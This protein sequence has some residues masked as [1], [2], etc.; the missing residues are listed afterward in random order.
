MPYIGKISQAAPTINH[1][2][3]SFDATEEL[4]LLGKDHA[5]I[6]KDDRIIGIVCVDNLLEEYKSGDIST[7]TIEEFIE[8]L[9]FVNE[10]EYRSK[11][12][13][14]MLVNNVEHIAVTNNAGEFVGIAS[15]NHLKMEA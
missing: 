13:E 3:S 8:P 11:A 2:T 6:K 12:A 14:I 1:Q 7:T 4:I 5:F 10:Y 15:L 9:F